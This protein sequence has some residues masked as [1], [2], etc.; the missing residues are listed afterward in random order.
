M[1]HPYLAKGYL[2]GIG[3]NSIQDSHITD[4]HQAA[5]CEKSM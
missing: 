4:G 1:P 2:T 5:P 3:L